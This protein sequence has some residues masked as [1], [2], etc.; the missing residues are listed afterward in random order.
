MPQLKCLAS[1]S[2]ATESFVA[3]RVYHFEEA[4]AARLMRGAPSSW[5]VVEGEV[6]IGGPDERVNYAERDRE[7][8]GAAD[9]RAAAK[10]EQNVADAQAHEQALRARAD[11][12]RAAEDE[13]EAA[14]LAEA[15]TA[16][17]EPEPPD[18]EEGEDVDPL[19]DMTN[20]QLRE[21]AEGLNI[22]LGS[23]RTKP[24]IIAAIR[25]DDDEEGD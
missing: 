20:A 3:D 22:A 6:E 12:E 13:A 21:H 5:E 9:A 4:V 16:N 18:E 24:E 15:H 2:E 8:V 7:A 1:Y 10:H 17:R 25:G 11:G 23:A 14:R 19:D